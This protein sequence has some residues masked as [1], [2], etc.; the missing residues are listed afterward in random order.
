MAPAQDSP[1]A[2]DAQAGFIERVGLFAPKNKPDPYAHRRGE[3]RSFIALWVLYVVGAILLSLTALG[4]RGF[5]D[6][7]VYRVGLSRLMVALVAGLVL[8]WP[9][10]RLS[11]VGPRQVVRS[12]VGDWCIVMMPLMGVVLPQALPWMDVWPAAFAC[13]VTLWCGA[14]GL[15]VVGV[16]CNVFATREDASHGARM[17]GIGVLALA[18]LVPVAFLPFVE[19]RPQGSGQG[20][21]FTAWLLPSPIGGMWDMLRDRGWSGSAARLAPQHWTASLVVLGVGVLLVAIGW[22][23]RAM[24]SPPPTR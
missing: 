24:H 15:V 22:A 2:G 5:L 7:G 4:A 23:R 13:C 21:L 6:M 8:V 12:F 16:L 10:L 11:Q 3:P 1:P 19:T 17:L 18:C 20:L 9:M 14:W